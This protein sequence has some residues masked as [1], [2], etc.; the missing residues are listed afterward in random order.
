MFSKTVRR[1]LWVAAAA[2]AAVL[3]VAVVLS[4]EYSAASLWLPVLALI[5]FAAM[6]VRLMLRGDFRQEPLDRAA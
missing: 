5:L 4:N 2:L 3:C 6:T 1:S